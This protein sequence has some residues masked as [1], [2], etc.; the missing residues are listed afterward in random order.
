MPDR[1]VDDEPASYHPITRRYLRYLL[2]SLNDEDSGGGTFAQ[3]A[4]HLIQRRK[5]ANIVPATEPSAGGDLGQDARTQRV[6]LDSDGRFRLYQS[7]PIVQERWIFA[8]SIR[9]DW[10]A[11]LRSDAAKIIANNLHPDLIVFVTNQFIN[12]EH[13]KIDAERAITQQHGVSCEILDGQWIL[14]QLYEQDYPLAVE[15]LGCPPETDPKLMDMFRRLYGL[16]E[17]GLSEEEAVEL[18]QLKSQVQYRN[19]YIDT[20]EHLIQDM[21]RIGNI[22]APYEAYI[23]E[24][25]RWYEEALPELD[26]ITNLSDGIELLYSYFKA[27]QKL[28]EGLFKIF[29][30]LPKFIDMVFATEARSMYHYVSVWLHRLFP[31]MRG[32][33]KFDSLFRIT[34]DRFRAIDR[35]RL[36][37]LSK[38][39]LD[40]TILFLEFPLIYENDQEV[41]RWLQRIHS[42]LQSIS[43]I[44]AFPRYHIVGL[45]GVLAPHLGHIAEYETCFELATELKSEQEGG[46]SKADT[47]KKRALAHARANQFEDALLQASRAQKIWLNEHSIRGYLLITHAMAHWYDQLGYAQAVEYELILGI[48]IATWQPAFM[49]SDIFLAMIVALSSI[50]L[51]QGRVL[52]AYRWLFYYQRICHM[53]RLEPDETILKELLEGNLIVLAAYL[54]LHNRLIHDRLVEIANNIDTNL[55]L[56][57]REINLSDDEEF[58]NWLSDLTPEQQEEVR[59]LRLKIQNEEPKLPEGFIEYDELAQEQYIEWQ[60]HLAIDDILTFRIHYRRDPILAQ[61]AFTIAVMIQIWSVFLNRDLAGLTL[62]DDQV[63]IV[64][65]W[66]KQEDTEPIYITSETV[67]DK[68]IITLTITP[69]YIKQVA[70]IDPDDFLAFF[71]KTVPHIIRELSID[72]PDEIMHLFDPETYGAGVNSMIMAGSPAFLWESAFTRTVM[73]VDDAS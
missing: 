51:K 23:E 52:R 12:P 64:L 65:E 27:L 34:L 37:S 55:L 5:C 49:E 47:Y 68:L 58:E 35:S 4:V 73:G 15:F 31:S 63:D 22:L 24:A 56:G 7:P 2:V 60:L 18:E 54:Y 20:P 25:L 40:E 3:L 16:E 41:L 48:N 59:N 50:A 53:Y 10:S 1:A 17:G 28:P 62:V 44:E 30:W 57:Y 38:A 42:F 39:Y 26:R 72:P 21:H 11:K 71:L 36:G 67:R 8:F 13:I 14:D 32:Q 9:Q 6:L 66:Q 29:A 61:M 46:L 45:L 43:T 69:Q 19:R 70:D 33:E